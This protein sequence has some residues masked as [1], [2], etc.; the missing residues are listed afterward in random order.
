MEYL[1]VKVFTKDLK[2]GLA[3]L[4][5]FRK[6][7]SG[8]LISSS[9][10]GVLVLNVL[11]GVRLTL[12]FRPKLND[13]DLCNLPTLPRSFLFGLRKGL[14]PTSGEVGADFLIF[15]S[16]SIVMLRPRLR[17]PERSNR[18]MLDTELRRF[19]LGKIFISTTR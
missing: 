11:V 16:S 14:R 17:D 7:G 6:S 13:P 1:E 3:A 10:R 12:T 8:L 9:G 5:V 4:V 15:P 2:P 18:G 19:S